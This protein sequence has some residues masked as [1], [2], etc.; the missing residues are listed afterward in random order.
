[1]EQEGLDVWR[2]HAVHVPDVAV[3]QLS[4][5]YCRG[6]VDLAPAVDLEISP[7]APR[8]PCQSAGYSDND[9]ARYPLSGKVLAPLQGI[10]ALWR[11]GSR[12]AARERF[13]FLNIAT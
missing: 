5:Q 1:M 8:E 4:L 7:M 3:Q 10:G 2:E 9:P 11:G 13:I 6:H 12:L